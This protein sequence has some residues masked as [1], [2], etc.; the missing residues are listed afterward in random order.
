MPINSAIIH[1][2]V[3]TIQYLRDYRTF[4]GCERSLGLSLVGSVFVF[5][6]L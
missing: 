2:G 4:V 3:Y 5:Y 1:H 6:C